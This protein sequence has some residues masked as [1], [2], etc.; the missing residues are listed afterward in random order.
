ME[1]CDILR[2]VINNEKDLEEKQVPVNEVKDKLKKQIKQ[3]KSLILQIECSLDI[4][5]F[6]NTKCIFRSNLVSNLNTDKVPNI[7]LQLK[8]E[9]YR[10]SGFYCIKFSEN[11]YIFNFS[12]LNK[13]D[14]KNIFAIQILNNQKKG[15]LGKWVMPMSI[16]LNDLTSDFPITELRKIPHFLKICKQHIDSYFIRQTQYTALMDIISHTKNSTLQS[17]LGYTQISLELM[18]LYYKNTDSYINIIIYLLYNISEAR[19]HKI[20]V[21]STT[22]NELDQN[23]K[24]HL[25]KS[26]VCFKQFD[27]HKAFENMLNL[28][29]F[30][31]TKEN[32]ED[33]PLEINNLSNSDEEG[34][35][36]TYSIIQN[37]S[38][39]H[40]KKRR[41]KRKIKEENFSNILNLHENPI[42]NKEQ[43]SQ[44]IKQNIDV[45]K[46]TP[47]LTNFKEK[48]L[49]QTKLKFHL[50]NLE[51][52]SSDTI[53]FKH[54]QINKKLIKPLTS[55]PIHQNK[56]S[57]DSIT[58]TSI[59]DI[60]ITKNNS[61][62]DRK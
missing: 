38:Q 37:K 55:T 20:E 39:T 3:L 16:D 36:S 56:H 54:M 2:N 15:T 49:K 41:K 27:L 23:V 11:E 33:S 30:K 26:L 25:Q 12:P 7:N 48:R 21:N 45:I 1:V 46:L 28:E 40:H 14:R 29:A 22:Q 59:S 52:E 32:A 61:D 43:I 19:P 13:Y 6:K 24:K 47:K 51:N 60:T 34:F 8:S 53:A 62:I 9:L 35:L 42:Q 44:N 5:K 4:L 10:Y 31:W 18:G 17:N 58:S 57:S 50:N